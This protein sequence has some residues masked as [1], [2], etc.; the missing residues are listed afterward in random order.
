MSSNLVSALAIARML[1]GGST[2]LFP[3][4]VAPFFGIPLAAQTTIVAR[5]FGIRDFI[6]G[7][8]VWTARADDKAASKS[9]ASQ[10]G[11]RRELRRALVA[12]ILTDA[13]DLCSAVV[14]VLDGT[15]EGPAIGW[16]AGGAAAMLALGVVTLRGL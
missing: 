2:L 14:G 9:A 13:V 8:L 5:L 10:E 3:H 16:V 12:G 6:L 1:F 7:G 4:H 11:N 15:L